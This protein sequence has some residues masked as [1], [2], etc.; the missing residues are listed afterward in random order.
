MP[1]VAV[2]QV[3]T[4]VLVRGCD[5]STPPKGGVCFGAHHPPDRGARR[6]VATGFADGAVLNNTGDMVLADL[7]NETCPQAAVLRQAGTWPRGSFR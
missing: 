6:P 2:S 1:V 5:I 7:Y 4:K 3:D